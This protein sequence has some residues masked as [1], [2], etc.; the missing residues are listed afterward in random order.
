MLDTGNL[1]PIVWT[2]MAVIFGTLLDL[3][4]ILFSLYG[5]NVYVSYYIY[6]L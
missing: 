5:V 6:R 2:Y 4:L 3:M 1:K